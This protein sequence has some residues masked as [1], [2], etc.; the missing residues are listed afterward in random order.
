MYKCK[1]THFALAHLD[2][3]IILLS[4]STVLDATVYDPSPST[5]I[6]I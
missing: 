4:K 5:L 2:F 3:D 6:N 1:G